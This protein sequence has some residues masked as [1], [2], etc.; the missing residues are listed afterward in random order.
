MA[1]LR[2]GDEAAAAEIFQRFSTRLLAL[3]SSRLGG[4]VRNKVDP[5]DVLQSAYKSFFH[6]HKRGEFVLDNWDTLLSLLVKITLRKCGHRIEYFHAACRDVKRE[7]APS[8]SPDDS[9]V[10]WQAIARDPTPSEAAILAETAEEAMRGFEAYQ[11][12]IVRRSLDGLTVEEI[13]DEIR[14]SKRTVQRVLKR[15]RR[16]L[17]RL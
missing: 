7:T 5:E 15:V 1:R 11:R 4:R 2:T 3:A 9:A 10:S 14:Y 17:E 6:R 13:S 16:R 12:E 8:P